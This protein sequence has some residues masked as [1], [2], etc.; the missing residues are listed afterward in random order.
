MNRLLIGESSDDMEAGHKDSA[1]ALETVAKCDLCG[2]L[3]FVSE[4]YVKGWSLVKCIACGLVFTSPRRRAACLTEMY[5]HNYY[6]H[7]KDYLLAQLGEST[8]EERRLV[9]WLSGMISSRAGS[10]SR[11]CL[12]VGCGAGKFVREF[13]RGGWEATGIDL[14][15]KAVALGLAQGLNLMTGDLSCRSL[16]TYDLISALHVIEHVHS[17]RAFLQQC[18]SHLQ[19]D[20]CLLLEIPDYG[21]RRSRQLGGSWPYLYPDS[22]LFQFT[23][24]TLTRYL[25]QSGFERVECHQCHGMAWLEDYSTVAGTDRRKVQWKRR[26]FGCRHLITWCPP[27]RTLVKRVIWEQL[28]YGEFLRVLARKRVG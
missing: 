18:A 28:R 2:G 24:E 4:R 7:D 3:D 11:R 8:D 21:C 9:K 16:T 20:G 27:L 5:V 15:E 17:P 26:A 19:D 23:K 22:H 12:D 1:E 14:S 10:G 25:E 13:M 6:E